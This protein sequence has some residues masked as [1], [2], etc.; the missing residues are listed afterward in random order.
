MVDP[1]RAHSAWRVNDDEVDRNRVRDGVH[2]VVDL[3]SGVTAWQ[4]VHAVVLR[5][6]RCVLDVQFRSTQRAVAAPTVV[7]CLVPRSCLEGEALL[8][9]EE[10]GRD[11]GWAR[12]RRRRR[13]QQ[14]SHVYVHGMEEGIQVR[15]ATA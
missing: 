15:V 2:V 1:T 7:A 5:R 10:E 4:M 13:E 8:D 9:E 14:H 12:R 11:V 3:R 6:L